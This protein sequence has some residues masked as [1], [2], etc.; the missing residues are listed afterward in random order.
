LT[1]QA[2]VSDG[3]GVLIRL[4]VEQVGHAGKDQSVHRHGGCESRKFV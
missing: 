2:G 4:G 3:D 1:L